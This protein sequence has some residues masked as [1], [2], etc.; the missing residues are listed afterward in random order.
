MGKD[1]YTG[2]VVLWIGNL[3]G[4]CVELDPPTDTQD[5]LLQLHLDNPRYDRINSAL[6]HSA[7]H[8]STITVYID[9]NYSASL[10]RIWDIDWWKWTSDAK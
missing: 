2:T 8:Q 4:V 7:Y 9:T 3:E 5:G 10:P 1:S 6:M